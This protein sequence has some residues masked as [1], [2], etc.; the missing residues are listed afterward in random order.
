MYLDVL[1]HYISFYPSSSAPKGLAESRRRPAALGSASS[2]FV[3][4]LDHRQSFPA[5][6]PHELDPLPL[7]PR[8]PHESACR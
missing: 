3:E 7:D 8:Q 1:F 5:Q 6:K 2:G 4:L